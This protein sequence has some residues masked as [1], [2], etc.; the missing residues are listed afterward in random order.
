MLKQYKKTGF[1]EFKFFELLVATLKNNENVSLIIKDNLEVA[2][3][4]LK[5]DEELKPILKNLCFIDQLDNKRV[6]LN[7]AFLA[8]N[9]GGLI[10]RV[11]DSDAG[12][13]IINISKEDA[14]IIVKNHDNV[15][16]ELMN[17]LVQKINSKYACNENT[18]EGYV[19]KR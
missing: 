1:T 5:N 18:E 9:I 15:D 13:Y 14:A 12:K 17:K 2:L 7:N 11:H 8:A 19:K 10:N 6:D 3:F 16:V 4:D